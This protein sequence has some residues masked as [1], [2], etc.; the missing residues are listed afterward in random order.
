MHISI[1]IIDISVY[2]VGVVDSRIRA[3]LLHVG[4]GQ[5][6]AAHHKDVKFSELLDVVDGKLEAALDLQVANVCRENAADAAADL[7]IY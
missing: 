6:A 1:E 3:L 5:I 4:H 7:H 2:T